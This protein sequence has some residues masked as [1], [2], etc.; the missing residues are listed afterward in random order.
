MR[1]PFSSTSISFKSCRRK[2]SA[3]VSTRAS[4]PLG[5]GDDDDTAASP[6]AGAGLFPF[7]LIWL[8]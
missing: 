1:T 3:S 8:S 5:L 6:R 4:T 7:A 2:I